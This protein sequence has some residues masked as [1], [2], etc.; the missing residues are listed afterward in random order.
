MSQQEIARRQL[1][2]LTL[3]PRDKRVEELS[4]LNKGLHTI[5]RDLRE[6]RKS[7]LVSRMEILEKEVANESDYSRRLVLERQLLKLKTTWRVLV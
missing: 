7:D 2:A 6:E 1:E 5:L 4:Q 3:E